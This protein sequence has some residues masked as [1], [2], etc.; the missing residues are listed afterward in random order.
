MKIT[1]LFFVWMLFLSFF[2]TVSWSYAQDEYFLKDGTRAV[3]IEKQLVLFDLNSKR[4]FAPPGN[5]ETRDGRYIIVVKK[6]NHAVVM[7]RTK[8]SR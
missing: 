6:T 1:R 5:Y 8:E 7:E 3:I 4:T 2:F